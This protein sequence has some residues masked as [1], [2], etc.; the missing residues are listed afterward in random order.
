MPLNFST[1]VYLPVYDYFARPVIFTPSG[2]GSPYNARGV[3]DT[4]D[5]DLI[6]EDGSV[7]SDQ[8]TVLYIREIEFSVLPKQFDLVSIPAVEDIPAAGDFVVNDAGSN[9]GGETKLELRKQVTP[10]PP[11]AV[12]LVGIQGSA[13][14]VLAPLGV[15]AS[16]SVA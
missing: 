9:G 8:K 2:G 16:G 11:N 14:Q 1:L 6:L 7:F 12:V 5:I 10:K 13:Y 15:A 3:F 4:D